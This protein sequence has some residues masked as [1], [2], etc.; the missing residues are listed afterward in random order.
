VATSKVKV[1]LL[2]I[3]PDCEKVI[4]LAGRT[5]YMSLD[6]RGEE[7]APKF[8]RMLVTRGHH[9]VLEHATATFAVS[10]ISR[11]CTHQLVR[12]RL[13]SF[14]QK[15]QRYVSEDRAAFVVPET[16]SANE[17]ALRVF[18]ESTSGSHASYE[19]LM[20]LGI[21]RE[22]ARFVI[23]G[24]VETDI[25]L[26]ANLRELRHVVEL[27]GSRH[28]QWEIRELAVAMLAVLKRHAPNVFFDLE[29][30]ADGCI[31]RKAY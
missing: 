6:R 26:S 21:P 29:V 1:E 2:T 4:E 25:V 15:S 20:D 3:T 16:I 27:R 23:P 17:E 12:H 28:A 14:S 30:G 19:K 10:G 18:T 9:S 7:S 11:A 31:V 22:D 8:V 24:A 13:C 5:C